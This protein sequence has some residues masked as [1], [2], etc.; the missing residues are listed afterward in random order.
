MGT[1]TSSSTPE[2]DRKACV[3]DM[4]DYVKTLVEQFGHFNGAMGMGEGGTTLHTAFGGGRLAFDSVELNIH[5]SGLPY[6]ESW[7]ASMMGKIKS[8]GRVAYF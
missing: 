3:P 1:D 2:D 6:K 5:I 7:R 8:T 4:R